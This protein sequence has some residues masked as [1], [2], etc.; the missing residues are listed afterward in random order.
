MARFSLS[1]WDRAQVK[2]FNQMQIF[3]KLLAGTHD[4]FYIDPNDPVGVLKEMI[5]DLEGILQ[6]QQ[7]LIFSRK[8][9]ENEPAFQDHSFQRGPII[10]LVLWIREGL[11]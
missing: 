2:L 7:R 8:Q 11:N 10:H 4:T 1:E 6:D 3:V 5:Q 9:L